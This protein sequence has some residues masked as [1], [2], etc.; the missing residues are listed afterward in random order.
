[1]TTHYCAVQLLSED[2]N[3]GTQGESDPWKMT[4]RH[5]LIFPVREQYFD[6]DGGH[7]TE[8]EKKNMMDRTVP[9]HS[10]PIPAEILLKMGTV[11][12]PTLWMCSVSSL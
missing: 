11:T 9:G 3:K 12:M 4:S 7:F 1:M 8:A 6:R 2:H 10:V 5:S